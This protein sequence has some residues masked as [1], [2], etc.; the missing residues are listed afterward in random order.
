MQQEDSDAP[1]VPITVRQLEA[2]VRIS[3]SL[4]R[5]GLQM[6]AGQQHVQQALELFQVRAHA[7]PLAGCRLV[8]LALTHGACTCLCAT[9]CVPCAQQRCHPP[10]PGPARRALGRASRRGPGPNARSAALQAPLR[11]PAPGPAA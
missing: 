4:A 5:M 2:I 8:A 1:P 9:A 7:W 3:E 10:T 6:V 11:L